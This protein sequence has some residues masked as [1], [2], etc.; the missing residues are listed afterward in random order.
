ML[1][2]V[3]EPAPVMWPGGR[4]V[5]VQQ[6]RCLACA[7]SDIVRRD[8]HEDNEGHKHK[9]GTASPGDGVRF[10]AIPISMDGGPE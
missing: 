2:P 4:V 7:A 3:G 5:E 10:V 6:Y 9:R 8:F 1:V